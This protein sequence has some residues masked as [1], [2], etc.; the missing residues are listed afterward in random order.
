LESYGKL[1]EVIV[2][3][4][5]FL[6]AKAK[7]TFIIDDPSGNSYIENLCAP[8]PDPRLKAINYRQTAEQLREM[9]FQSD[10]VSNDEGINPHPESVYCFQ[11]NCSS[12]SSP[13]ETRM[14][15][16]EI[17]HFREVIIM[18]TTCDYCGYKTNEVKSGGATSAY[19]KKITLQLTTEED[20]S[21]DI[22][23]SETCT[24]SIPE[25]DL[26]LT[27][28][29]LGGRF[30]TLEGLLRQVY[31]ELNDKVPFL[32]GDSALPEQKKAFGNL[33]EKIDKI[34]SSELLCRVIL[35]DPLGNSYLQNIYAPDDDPNMTI[36][37][38]ERSFDQNEEL[39][40]NDI[41]VD[42]YQEEQ[43]NRPT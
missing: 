7:F 14:H 5:N 30:T 42:G 39:G 27:T 11:T 31:D 32:A 6:T 17:P 41:K 28:N 13:C 18:A 35:D 34:C 25:I 1:Q 3:L 33:L 26:L 15:A 24:L 43:N 9:G 2:K 20:L 23:K 37:N 16:I 38:Y 22:L 8:R 36:E 19:G 4:N 21:R 12:C 10:D 29:S 40:L